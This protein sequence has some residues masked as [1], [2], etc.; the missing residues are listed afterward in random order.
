MHIPDGF[1]DVK[2]SATAAVLSAA[3]CALALSRLRKRMPPQR[4]PLMGVTAAFIFAAQMINFPVAGG[5]SGHL[6]GGVLAAVLVGPSAAVIVLASVLVVQCFLFADGGVLSLGANVLNMAVVAPLLGIAVERLLRMVL[7]SLRGRL[8]AAGFA[9]WC[10]TVAAATCA[11]GELAWSGTAPWGVAFPAMFHVHMLIGVGEGVITMLVLSALLRL[12]P[13]LLQEKPAV[14]DRGAAALVGYGALVI[15]ALVVFVLPFASGWPDGLQRV[16]A[17]LG[18]DHKA[19]ASGAP[20]EGYRVPGIDTLGPATVIS[21]LVGA[22]LVFVLAYFLA[23][24]L[25]AGHSVIH[26]ERR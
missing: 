8:L 7:P 1:L 10:S 26:P 6:I 5:T 19:V 11:A 18:F 16:A 9:G 2:T 24:F 4:I 20:L 13:E 12:R 21:G 3:G 14:Q 15:V 25:A 23:R 17:V 22:A